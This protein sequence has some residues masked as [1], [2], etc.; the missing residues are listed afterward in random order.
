M[1]PDLEARPAVVAALAVASAAALI[2]PVLAALLW[3]RRSGAPMSVWA[4][5]ALVFFVSQC[6]LRLP[7][8]IPLGVWLR[9]HIQASQ[10]LGYAWIGVSALTAGI[11]EEVGRWAGYRWLVKGERSFRVGVMFGLGHGGI[12]A[13]LLVGLSLAGSLVLY[14]L[15]ATGHA[16]AMGAEA[17]DKLVTAMSA[18]RARDLAASVLERV[19]AMTVQ[20]ALSLV[21]L[22]AVVRRSKAWLAGAVAAHFAVDF[23]SVLGAVHLKSHGAL[24]MELAVVPSFV[25]GIVVI[26]V[27]RRTWKKRASTA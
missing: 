10:V 15:L 26:A 17:H 8:Q 9:P 11:F 23:V 13:M 2:G 19:M 22:E 24:V 16:P 3:S 14:V 21:V 27:S 1:T 20:V 25:A 12:E 4:K 5:G 18:L 6:V 7:W